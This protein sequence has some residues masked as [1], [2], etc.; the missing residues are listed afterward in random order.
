[1]FWWLAPKTTHTKK[2]PELKLLT[3][4]YLVFTCCSMLW[5]THTHTITTPDSIQKKIFFSFSHIHIHDKCHCYCSFFWW[6]CVKVDAL[7]DDVENP[8]TCP[9]CHPARRSAKV[10]DSEEK[11]HVDCPCGLHEQ[12]WR[13]IGEFWF[14]V[15][16]RAVQRI[17]LSLL[18]FLMSANEKNR[19]LALFT[20]FCFLVSAPKNVGEM[21]PHL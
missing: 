11:P 19:T 7:G 3:S 14:G 5:K 16:T 15:Y 8:S 12:F 13:K 21:Y 2:N 20:N 4:F 6:C 18:F 10:I 1:M 17:F 9:G